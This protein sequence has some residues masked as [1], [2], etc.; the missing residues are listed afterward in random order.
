MS[1]ALSRT[2]ANRLL[3]FEALGTVLFAVPMLMVTTAGHPR[4]PAWAQLLGLAL[5]LTMIGVLVHTCRPTIVDGL[6]LVTRGAT[7]SGECVTR[8]LGQQSGAERRLGW[9]LVL[10]PAV[11]VLLLPV[12]DTWMRFWFWSTLLLSLSGMLSLGM[13]LRGKGHA[14]C[15]RRQRS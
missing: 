3:A 14:D 11:L 12:P 4:V 13:L 10:Y 9:L 7:G 2:P 6:M 15:R 8:R 1:T 5:L